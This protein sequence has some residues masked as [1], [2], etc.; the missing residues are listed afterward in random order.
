MKRKMKGEEGG[1]D[2]KGRGEEREMHT[3]K[4]QPAYERDSSVTT[5]PK[6]S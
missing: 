1:D 6:M 4:A 2:E 3:K 5:T